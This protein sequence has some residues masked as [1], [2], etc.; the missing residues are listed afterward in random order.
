MLLLGA[1]DVSVRTVEGSHL[2]HTEILGEYNTSGLF[3]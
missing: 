3:C 2:V 1:S